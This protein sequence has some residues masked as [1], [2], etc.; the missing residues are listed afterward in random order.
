MNKSLLAIGIIFVGLTS[1]H[2]SFKS[3]V[4]EAEKATFIIYTFDEFGSPAGLGS[5]FFIDAEGTGI[6]NYHVLD[7]AVKAII[8]TFDDNEYEINSVIASDKNWD[9]VKFSIKNNGETFKPLKF[10]KRKI[11]KGD[12]VYNISNPLGLEKTISNGIVSS[13][14]DDKQLGDIVQITA[15][16]SSGSSGSPILDINGDVFAVATFMRRGGQNLNFGVLIDKDKIDYFMK[17][18][19]SKKN[20]KFNAQSNFV[21]LNIPADDGANITLN[22]IEFGKTSTTLYLSYTHLNL[23]S[24]DYFVWCELNKKEQGFTIEDVDTKKQYYLTSSTIGI[25]KANATK[26][27]LAATM[28]FKVYFPVIKDDIKR[29]N[30]YGCGKNDSRWQFKDINLRKYKE[31]ANVNFEDYT[32]DYALAS[33][34]EGVY[35]DAN[36]M[37]LEFVEN[38]PNDMIAL[39]ALGILSYIADNN[40]DALYYF[41]EAID[42]NPNDELAYV[43]RFAVYRYQNNYTAAL[44]D[45]T[46]AINVVPEQAD[47]F[48][49]RALL[50]MD[51]E[52]WKNA[53]NDL[54]KAIDSK[55]YKRNAEIYLLRIYANAYLGNSKDACNDIYTAFNLTN[56]KELEEK[57]QD[58]WYEWGCKK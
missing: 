55:D 4:N 54:D 36:N 57:L 10:S 8:K 43:N 19:F 35:G 24:K 50:Y 25:D 48:V 16:I 22:A 32:R 40:S 56:D 12:V 37:L 6:T 15:P 13:L 11:E 31:K 3:I 46:Q 30:I 52:D 1:C 33:L 17:S 18:D 47:N 5:G 49:Q 58:L 23:T 2:K 28:K 44:A 20:N 27:D 51:M 39:N 26:V 41:S 42:N 53:K 38:N 34:R 29:I 45:I 14:R 7:G 21:I 9:I